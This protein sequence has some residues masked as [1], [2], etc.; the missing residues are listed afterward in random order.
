MPP[1]WPS[2]SGS[3]LRALIERYCGSPLR[4][5]GS[6]RRYQGLRE[7]FTYGYHD[8]RTVSGPMVRRILVKDVG[9]KEEDA[10]K[11]VGL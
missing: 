8:G 11:A 9:L 5:S 10:R 2:M 3:K 7:A 4:Q 6:H 1:R